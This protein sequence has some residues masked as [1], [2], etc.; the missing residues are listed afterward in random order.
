M[1]TKTLSF[2][3]L[4]KLPDTYTANTIYLIKNST[5]SEFIDFYISGENGDNLFKLPSLSD[6]NTA[7]YSGFS[8]QFI[9]VSNLTSLDNIAM[10]HDNIG[11][12]WVL[13][14]EG[15]PNTNGLP[16]PYIYVPAS[17]DSGT[18]YCMFNI[19]YVK[20]NI[21]WNDIQN[22]PKSTPE[23]IDQVVAWWKLNNQPL[24]EIESSWNDISSFYTEYSNSLVSLDEY[25]D[26]YG[27]FLPYNGIMPY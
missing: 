1:A 14:T 19:N 18:W 8:N 12:A 25:W 17:K 20:N 21:D 4:L 5:S 9:I 13:D 11:I 22:T 10:D 7:I 23:E 16:A 15:D 26:A 3:K 2:Q 27:G 24:A 6:I